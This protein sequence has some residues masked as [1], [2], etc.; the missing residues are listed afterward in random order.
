MHAN[1]TYNCVIGNCIKDA[2]SPPGPSPAPPGPHPAPSPGPQPPHLTPDQRALSGIQAHNDALQWLWNQVDVLM[3]EL[4][5][6]EDEDASFIRGYLTE[7]E[8]LVQNAHAAGNTKLSI[9]PFTWQRYSRTDTKFLD[10]E[11][12]KAEFEVPFEFPHVEAVLVRASLASHACGRD[13]ESERHRDLHLLSVGLGRP[14]DRACDRRPNQCS[15][16]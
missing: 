13:R 7:T 16:Q 1:E 10:L 9:V 2:P 8:R 5:L 14:C 3:P 6:S 4:Y 12:L 15:F 11:H